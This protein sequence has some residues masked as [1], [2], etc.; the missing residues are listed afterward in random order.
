MESKFHKWFT[1]FCLLTYLRQGCLLVS[2]GLGADGEPL[3][4]VEV[5]SERHIWQALLVISV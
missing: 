5:I 1:M 4:S 3:D 2:G